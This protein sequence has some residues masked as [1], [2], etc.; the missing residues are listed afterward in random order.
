MGK[1]PLWLN[2]DETSVPVVFGHAKGNIMVNN[3][4]LGWVTQ[5]KQILSRSSRRTF[6]THVGLICN[7][8]WLQP[9]LPQV[10]FV[11]AKS[12]SW[13]NFNLL[14]D[15]LPANVFLKRMP[16]GWNSTAQ[17]L[18]IIRIL[19]LV[20][21]PYLDR[22]Q[23]ILSFDAAPLHLCTSIFAELKAAMI[24]FIVVPARL[25]WLFQPLDTHG[26]MKYKRFLRNRF[27]D[28]VV[29]GSTGGE[30]VRM[31]KLVVEAIRVVLQGTKWQKAFDDTG[32]S[33]T[34]EHV[35]EYI[36]RQLEWPTLP[37]ITSE[38]P[39]ALAIKNCWPR[40]RPF[41]EAEVFSAF[42]IADGCLEV[43]PALADVE[44]SPIGVLSDCHFSPAFSAD[45]V[46][47][48]DSESPGSFISVPPTIDVN[49]TD[50]SVEVTSPVYVAKPK[51]RLVKKT[52]MV[53][54]SL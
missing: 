1:E 38:C 11:G 7:L 12:L 10:I 36:K 23:P 32:S 29:D 54:D 26:F 19:G 43:L 20:L 45:S 28:S 31:I 2:L 24:W 6:F 30:V 27:K 52:S 5:A 15:S 22:Y 44:S 42:P 49:S 17:H 3:G 50:E 40:N 51:H 48:A 4:R 47:S 13:E 18:I 14:A 35:S 53:P 46:H 33:G 41:E 16:K 37:A 34:T 25:T 8:T 9:L 21:Q 39:S